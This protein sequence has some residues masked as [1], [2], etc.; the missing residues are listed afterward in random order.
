MNYFI[1]DPER[2]GFEYFKTIEECKDRFN[3]TK[4]YYM[5]SG[6]WCDD[7][8]SVF[9]GQVLFKC[10]KINIKTKPNKS[11]LDEDGFDEDGNDFSYFDEICDYELKQVEEIIQLRKEVERLKEKLLIESKRY[12]LAKEKLSRANAEISDLEKQT[13]EQKRMLEK[14]ED[15][16]VALMKEH[17]CGDCAYFDDCDYEKKSCLQKVKEDLAVRIF[18]K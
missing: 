4:D 5:D 10:E 15:W 16:I 3:E 9:V 1:Y 14:A 2:C 8:E 18:M 17:E 12:L 13:A 11:E 7:I 6:E